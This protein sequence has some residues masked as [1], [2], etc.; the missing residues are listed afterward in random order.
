MNRK[1][2]GGPYIVSGLPKPWG[3]PEEIECQTWSY[4]CAEMRKLL[5]AG[6]TN[7]TVSFV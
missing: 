1:I 4:A 3:K 5:I 7:V 2:N 6:Y